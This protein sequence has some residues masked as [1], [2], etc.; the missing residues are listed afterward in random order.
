MG[1]WTGYGFARSGVRSWPCVWSAEV[2]TFLNLFFKKICKIEIKM[3]HRIL[4]KIKL[5]V[6][7]AQ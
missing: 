1:V 6:L 3:P 4:V 7:G 5:E 2:I